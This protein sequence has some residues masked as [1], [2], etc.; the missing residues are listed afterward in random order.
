M[1]GR[2]R[3]G[4]LRAMEVFEAFFEQTLGLTGAEELTVQDVLLGVPFKRKGRNTFPV[5]HF[6]PAR[7]RG[8]FLSAFGVSLP[9]DEVSRLRSEEFS[10]DSKYM[11]RLLMM[12][13]LIPW[14]VVCALAG[15]IEDGLGRAHVVFPYEESQVVNTGK[16]H[17][18]TKNDKATAYSRFLERP[19]EGVLRAVSRPLCVDKTS[20][21][22][23]GVSRSSFGEV[24]GEPED[25]SWVVKEQECGPSQ[26]ARMKPKQYKFV[27]E[28]AA[29]LL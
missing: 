20:F 6:L 9:P 2:P 29:C 22:D 12:E 15:F 5:N 26:S 17:R 14:W 23:R 10:V 18:V 21:H 13:S 16:R 7:D 11:L 27:L 19:E 24:G 3:A 28:E 8:V 4:N 1:R 25:F